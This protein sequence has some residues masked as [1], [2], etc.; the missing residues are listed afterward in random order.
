[1][2][3]AVGII[4]WL[5][6]AEGV[7]FLIRPEFLGPVI[8]FFSNS[9]W[10]HA[11]SILR[12]ALAV[13]FFLGAMQCR[14]RGIIV[15]FGLLMLIAGVAGLIVGRQMYNTILQWWQERNLVTVRLLAAV[16]VLIGAVIVYSV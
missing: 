15:G 7:L 10:M 12:I 16:V 11:L 13:L 3:I 5:I 8:R 9:F 2:R 6:V 14:I 4:G 1:M